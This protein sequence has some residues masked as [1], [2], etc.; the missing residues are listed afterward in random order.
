M[1]QKG[2]FLKFINIHTVILLGLLFSTVTLAENEFA[3]VKIV[4]PYIEL[5][6]GPGRGFPVFFVA[7]EGEW[8]EILMSK[9]RW[10]KVR[11]ASEKLGWVHKDQLKKTL[12]VD[13]KPVIINDPDFNE[14]MNRTWELGAL[15]GDFEGAA[16]IS[17]YGGYHF[18]HNLSSE[19]SVSQALGNFS[20]IRMATL[21]V[22][23]E[24]FPD[25]LPFTWLPYLEDVHITPFF[26][27]GVG[28]METLPRGTLVQ[29]IDRQDDLMFVTAGA[30]LYLTR[31]F[32]IRL[33]YRQFSVLTNRNE[34][35][36]VEEWKLGFSIFF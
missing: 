18:T 25:L 30:K 36:E 35:E 32:L 21:N 20:E 19:L 31:R 8:I 2:L 11:L 10:F 26:G 6:T 24:P 7:E 3:Q 28:I 4:D 23:N 14:Y 12:T 33:E 13:N 16:L 22:I 15:N 29:T 34:N 1:F 17:L 9:T 5:H 27:I